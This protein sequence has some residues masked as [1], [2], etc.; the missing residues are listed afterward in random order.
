MDWTKV[1]QF[2]H[3]G[4][5]YGKTTEQA[6]L[7]FKILCRKGTRRGEKGLRL[8]AKPCMLSIPFLKHARANDGSWLGAFTRWLIRHE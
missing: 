6:I 1:R 5:E 4:T 8:R 2:I 7:P 3:R